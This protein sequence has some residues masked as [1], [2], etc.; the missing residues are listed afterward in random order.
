MTKTGTSGSASVADGTTIGPLL[1]EVHAAEAAW[2]EGELPRLSR[3][4]R[5]ALRAARAVLLR[6]RH[7]REQAPAAGA[8]HTFEHRVEAG[9]PR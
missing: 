6:S 2:R 1:E 5:L 3:T 4:E 9:M 8:D 7:R